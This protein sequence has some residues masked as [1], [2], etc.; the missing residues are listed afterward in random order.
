M[1]ID[2]E[3]YTTELGLIYS[4]FNCALEMFQQQAAL[5]F[6]SSVCADPTIA[7]E[8]GERTMF[9]S[10]VAPFYSK[11]LA[12]FPGQLVDFL[13]SSARSLPFGLRGNVTQALI[14]LVNRKVLN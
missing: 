2:P 1:K 13:K 14:L 7:K 4:R 8:L 12:R 10:Q 11:E 9:L 3:G 6:T 5:R